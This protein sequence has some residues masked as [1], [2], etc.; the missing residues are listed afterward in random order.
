MR[1]LQE[2]TEDAAPA[3]TGRPVGR[4]KPLR[5]L[6]LGGLVALVAALLGRPRA[7]AQTQNPVG[8]NALKQQT[9]EMVSWVVLSDTYVDLSLEALRKKLDEIYPGEFLPPREKGN[10]AVDGTV[11]GQFLIQSAISGEAGLFLLNSVP[12]PYSDFSDY[13]R[14]IKD[15]TVR[16]KALAQCCWL[17]IDL[18]GETPGTDAYRFIGRAVGKLAPADAAFLVRPADGT[19][20]PFTEELR[21]QLASGQQIR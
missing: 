2:E 19:V 7:E 20:I 11:P 12:G 15:Q 5:R 13:A 21:H 4:A 10:F 9:R 17:S 14:F 16:K 3:A 1:T 6:V 8:S 18:I